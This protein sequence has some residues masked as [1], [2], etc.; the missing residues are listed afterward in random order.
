MEKILYVNACFKEGSR[1]NE[2]AQHLLSR[3]DG[4]TET[5]N[6]YEEDIKPLDAELI[7][8]R[9]KLLRSGDTDNEF[10]SLARQFAAADTIVIAAPYW[11]L[12]FPAVLRVYLEN[13]AVCS[14]TFRYSEK[15]IPVGLC[16]A[17][18]L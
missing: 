17:K 7:S 11:D 9:D 12:I 16:K 8:K 14:I 4:Q 3:L 1:T 15:G 5:V 13:V 6:L 10:F 2:L 18:R